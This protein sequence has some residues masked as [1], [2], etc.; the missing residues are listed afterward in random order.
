[1]GAHSYS[2]L[3]AHVGH[4]L[5]CVE[6]GPEHEHEGD[7]ANVAVECNTCGCVLMDF[8]LEV[9]VLKIMR[10]TDPVDPRKDQDHLGT[11]VCWHGRYTWLGDLQPTM[12]PEDWFK[13]HLPPE[14]LGSSVLMP[15]YLYDHSGLTISTE[16][17][18]CQF[19]SGQVGWIA[20]MPDDIKE[21]YG[22]INEESLKKAREC[23]LAE[24]KQYDQYLR[25]SVWGFEYGDDSCWDFFGDDLEETG[26]KDHL[27]EDAL[28]M[29]EAA[30]EAR[31]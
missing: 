5:A 7:P 30:W 11:M 10:H 1:M 24:V 31:E 6:Y 29:L 21:A 28:P 16:P 8:D 27:P 15:L 17:F 13:E 23:L 4:E 19:D 2:D 25:G 14:L 3:K 22:E 26:I 9:P 18:S 12:R 20:A